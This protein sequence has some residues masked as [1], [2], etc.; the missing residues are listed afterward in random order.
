MREVAFVLGEMLPEVST[1]QAAAASA[2][3]A[4]AVVVGGLLLH[5]IVYALLGRVARASVTPWAQ[6]LLDR[7]R[8]PARLLVPLL[9]LSLAVPS[10]DLP[11]RTLG[12]LGHLTTLLFIAAVA[13]L[14]VRL[15]R[16]LRD[17]LLARYD[18]AASDNL[19]ARRVYTQVQV[20]EKVLISVIIV[21]TA[22]LMLMTFE[23]VRQV[24][25]SILASAGVLGIILGFAAQKTIGT[26]FA[27]VQ[28]AITQP[29]RLEDVVIVEGEW[30]A[31][32]EITLTYVV[33]RIWDQRRLV[34]PITYFIE[35]PFENW[36]RTSAEVLGTVSLFMDYTV[37][38]DAVRAEFERV[39][40]HTD[41]WDG[42]AA[43]VQ[44]VSAS[45]EALEVRL[46]VSAA[47]AGKAWDLRCLVR[48]QMVAFI[49]ERYPG[50][51]PRIRAEVRSAAGA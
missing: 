33:V 16:V 50:S 36:T 24:G 4:L 28:I 9:L 13:Y 23:G 30:G 8:G 38:V 42:R 44:V 31:I 19:S 20:L 15:V 34:L 40:H 17:L 32:E 48:E 10:L 21:A 39:V 22:S 11:E 7:S 27:G 51:L 5:A 37:P 46:L 14:L 35:T 18:M 49:Q 47:D 6:P 1:V 29:I 43:S 26:L 2:A 3:I 45:A 41:L 12:M 25:V